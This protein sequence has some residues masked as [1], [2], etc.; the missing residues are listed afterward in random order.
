MSTNFP[1]SLTRCGHA[2]AVLQTGIQVPK[3]AE[4][5]LVAAQEALLDEARRL[6]ATGIIDSLRKC[7]TVLEALRA[8]IRIQKDDELGLVFMQ[9]A[10]LT[11]ARRLLAAEIED[12]ALAADKPQRTH[13]RDSLYFL[14]YITAH[15]KFS[16]PPIQAQT[17]SIMM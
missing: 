12:I 16:S 2:L 1:N 9:E 10:V 13:L 8:A 7:E 11:E 4:P 14:A 17:A 15:I 6:H 3:D 5:G